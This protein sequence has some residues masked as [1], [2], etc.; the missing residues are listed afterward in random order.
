MSLL[1]KRLAL[2]LCAEAIVGL[3]AVRPVQAQENWPVRPI[4]MIVPSS[5]GSGTDALARVMAQRLSESLKQPV[6]VENRPGGSGVIGTNAA[7]KAAPD[8][9]T[10]LYTTASNMVV[11]PAVIKSISPESRKS[12]VPIAQTAVGGVLLLVSPDLPVNDLPGLIEYVKAHPDK[13]S[14]GSWGTGSSAHLTMEWLK[15]QTGM[16]TEHVAYRTT[17]QLL[18]ELSSGVLKIGWTDPSVA[19]PFLRSGKVRGIAIVGNVRSPQLANVKTMSEQ[20]YKFGTVGWFGMFAPAGTSPAIVKR[21]SDE[22]NKVQGSP[23]IAALMN[24]LN[25]E[26]AP[27]KSSAQLGEIV[28][29]DLRVWT[30]IASDAAI[31]VEE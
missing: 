26:P 15:K 20:G 22:V 25:F 13:I 18:T 2:T 21:L 7:L 4:Q 1:R 29:N 28:Q 8:G 14:Y 24:K 17:T 16:K 30:K 11:A 27:V 6:V 31:R 12:L 3:C 10:I 5:P 23:E 19:V 9:Y